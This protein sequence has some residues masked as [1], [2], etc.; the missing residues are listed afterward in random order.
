MN[1]F[2]MKIVATL[3]VLA[4]AS[5]G[6]SIGDI[7]TG[8][9]AGPTFVVTKTADTN[10]GFC[11]ATDCSLREA[12]I[13]SNACSGTQTISIPAGTYHLTRIGATEDA[14]STGD[15]DLTDNVSIV[16]TGFP[17]IDGYHSDR[18][19]EI[20]PTKTVDMDGLII[21]NGRAPVGGGIRNEGI[22]H[23]HN[24]AIRLNVAIPGGPSPYPYPYPYPYPPG[25][26]G[27]GILAMPMPGGGGLG[28]GGG[29]LSE[30]DGALTL[31]NSEVI[32]NHAD[33]GGGIMVIANGT[34]SPTFNMNLTLVGFNEATLLGGGLWLDNAVHATLTSFAVRGNHAASGRGGGIWTAAALNMTQGTIVN[35]SGGSNGGGIYNEPAGE[36][37][38]T[39]VVIQNNLTQMGGGIY[40]AGLARFYQ[41]AIVNNEASGGQG[42]GAYISGPDGALL[43]DNSTLSGNQGSLGG[44][45]IRNDGGS[46]QI[47]YST[48]AYNNNDGINSTGSGEMHIRSSIVANHT[49]G[50]CVGSVPSSIG[51]NIDSANSCNFIEPSDLV[52]T[53]PLLMPL[54]AYGSSTLVHALNI[55]S[56]AIDSA[57]PD[58]CAG[59]DQRGIVRPQGPL[60]D[61][62]AFEREGG[63]PTPTPVPTATPTPSTF[64]FV[65][66]KNAFCRHGPGTVYPPLTSVNAG[67][68][69]ELLGQSEDGMWFYG[70]IPGNFR[71]WISKI[72]GEPSGDVS[73]LP[74]I[75]APPT[76]TP[77]VTPRPN[78]GPSGGGVDADGDGYPA[79]VDCNDNNPRIHPGA[80]ESPNDRIDSNCNG[81]PNK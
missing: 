64:I 48:I 7:F 79:G 57:D 46:F 27:A 8:L 26:G 17:K 14:A 65:I 30:G 53:D 29:I 28:N 67:Q 25:K 80:P 19:F 71:C 13:W 47:N 63:G 49:G 56:P 10:D 76:P 21:Q 16:G 51:F 6:C 72:A 32:N 11:T 74:R 1:K 55:S 42:G 20:M 60:C 38:G 54:G 40:T 15:L 78:K 4:V 52:N 59:S 66:T 2:I 34:A 9:C 41:S 3:T 5:S 18:V 61:R 70:I 22:L 37:T 24:S 36:L 73:L 31:D 69:A 68:Q 75:P 81:D 35:N 44:G 23:I 39:N 33:Q 58:R 12:V 77:T 43:L 50:N 45:A 62:G